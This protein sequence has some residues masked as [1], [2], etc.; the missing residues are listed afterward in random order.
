MLFYLQHRK[1]SH[2]LQNTADLVMSDKMNIAFGTPEPMRANFSGGEVDPITGEMKMFGGDDSKGGVQETS[3][4]A[5]MW[6]QTIGRNGMRSNPLFSPLDQDSEIGL[7]DYIATEPADEAGSVDSLSDFDEL[8]FENFADSLLQEFENAPPSATPGMPAISAETAQSLSSLD[9]DALLGNIGAGH[10]D[11]N[12]NV[13]DLDNMGGLGGTG[14]IVARVQYDEVN[15]GRAGLAGKGFAFDSYLANNADEAN[16]MF[17]KPVYD[18]ATDDKRR[19][20]FAKPAYA[21]QQHR[22]TQYDVAEQNWQQERQA[23][24]SRQIYDT[25]D[26][27]PAYNVAGGG[28]GSTIYDTASPTSGNFSRLD[29]S[30]HIPHVPDNPALH[31]HDDAMSASNLSE[32]SVEPAVVARV[33]FED[34]GSSAPAAPTHLDNSNVLFF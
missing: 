17:E 12:D 8:D 7:G 21:A 6:Q 32:F 31:V 30:F 1:D 24:G 4:D 33:H 26:P 23:A 14:P 15:S 9:I 27:K 16:G 19:T 3:F 29:G 11:G 22:R 20:Q 10:D 5:E 25:A 28:R 13:L 18:A 2:T 34:L